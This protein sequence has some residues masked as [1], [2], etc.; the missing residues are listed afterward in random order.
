MGSQ[1]PDAFFR[2]RQVSVFTDLQRS[3]WNPVLP[4]PDAPPPDYWARLRSKAEV[5]VIDT[6][7]A[8]LDNLAVA[9]ITL[10]NPLALVDTP[11]SVMV[12]VRNF[13]RSDKQLVRVEL[14]LLRPSSGENATPVPVESK[15][16]EVVENCFRTS[17]VI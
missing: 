12:Q 14:L 11:A 3:A 17:W 5:A 15:V 4:K 10:N 16:I 13:G 8:D 2:S 9:D 1:R 7:G 6:A